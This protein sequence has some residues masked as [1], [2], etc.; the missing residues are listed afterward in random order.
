M[1]EWAR[2]GDGLAGTEP[3]SSLMI[4][5]ERRFMFVHVPRT[6]GQSVERALFPSH[7]FSDREDPRHLYGWNAS[8]GWLNHLSVQ[9]SRAGGFVTPVLARRL[10]SFAFVRNPW[11]RLVSEYA[12]KFPDDCVSFHDFVSAIAGREDHRVIGRYRSLRAYEQHVR[13]QADYVIDQGGRSSVDFVG[14][15]EKLQA[16]FREVCR[17]I[18]APCIRLPHLNSSCRG[19]YADYYDRE[20]RMLASQVYAVDIARFGYSF[21]NERSTGA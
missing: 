15:W 10:F 17:Y 6:G 16:G 5:R 8:F 20:S 9:E 1:H 3:A 18:G 21:R 14:R 12:W 13:P 2:A 4:C 11:D 7:S 19:P